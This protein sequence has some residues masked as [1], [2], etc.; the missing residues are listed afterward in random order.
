M[1]V[2]LQVISKLAEPMYLM[3]RSGS[4]QNLYVSCFAMQQLRLSFPS[5]YTF[6]SSKQ[7]IV[8][9]NQNY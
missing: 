8:T 3:N 5:Q 7:F 9:T 6:S 1:L 2:S 4:L